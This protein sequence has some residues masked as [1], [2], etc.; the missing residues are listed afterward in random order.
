MVSA[1]LFYVTQNPK[2]PETQVVVKIV[3]RIVISNENEII[4]SMITDNK[5][6]QVIVMY[7]QFIKNEDIT[8]SIVLTALSAK[9]PI[10]LFFGLAWQESSFNP[11]AI[12]YNPRKGKTPAT[13]DVGLFQLN[14]R[15]FHDY[16]VEELK[17]VPLNCALAAEKLR[18]NFEKYGSWEE[19][20][21]GYNAGNTKNVCHDTIRHLV[22]VYYYKNLLD[23]LFYKEFCV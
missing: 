4:E 5:F 3:K 23:N 15:T 12:N 8:R 6:N 10:D 22:R 11:D 21:L 14:S 7:N 16:T 20:V 18:E 9:I 1:L 13:I 19:A 2:P 17:Q